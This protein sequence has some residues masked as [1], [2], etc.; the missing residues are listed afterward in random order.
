MFEVVA[1]GE[2]IKKG[3]DFI[4]FSLLQ[5]IKAKK[6]LGQFFA[7]AP[8]KAEIDAGQFLFLADMLD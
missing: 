6:L 3:E 7:P 8:G 5:E 1:A 4:S 2:F